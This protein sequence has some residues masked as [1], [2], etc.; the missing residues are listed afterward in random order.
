M[1]YSDRDHY[2][3]GYNW[4]IYQDPIIYPTRIINLTKEKIAGLFLASMD[5]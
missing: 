4:Y 3:C 1:D 2:L 5:N